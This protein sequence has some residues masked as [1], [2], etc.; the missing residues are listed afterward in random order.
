MSSVFVSVYAFTSGKNKEVQNEIFEENEIDEK[1]NEFHDTFALT[2]ESN[3]KFTD[4]EN[5][6]ADVKSTV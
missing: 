5:V 3:T 6:F 1:A 2:L 4:H